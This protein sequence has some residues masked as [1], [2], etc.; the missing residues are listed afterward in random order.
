MYEKG[1]QNFILF[2][3]LLTHVPFIHM[4]LFDLFAENITQTDSFA[5][6]WVEIPT[7]YLLQTVKHK[8]M[9]IEYVISFVS[10]FFKHV[11]SQGIHD[12]FLQPK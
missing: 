12:F 11:S 10:I 7:S 9:G 6:K 5:C 3:I 8:Y 2:L 4:F 1:K